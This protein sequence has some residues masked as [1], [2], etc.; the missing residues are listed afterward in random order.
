[1]SL[2][3]NFL[4]IIL[5]SQFVFT[6]AHANRTITIC[7]DINYWY[8]FSFVNDSKQADGL[9]I[10]ITREALRRLNLNTKYILRPWK[11]CL[12]SAELGEVDAIQSASYKTKRAEYLHYP[13]DA[14]QT[15]VS[16]WRLSQVEYFVI[17]STLKRDGSA[18]TYEFAGN[19]KSLPRPVRAEFGYSIVGDLEKE[20]IKVATAHKTL[21]LYRQLVNSKAGCVISLADIANILQEKEEFKGNLKVHDLPVKSKSYFLPFAKSSK[22][23]TNQDH[24]DIWNMISSIRDDGSLIQDWLEKY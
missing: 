9:H 4:L 21:A 13:D 18:Q 7:A 16:K 14:G 11:R 12:L 23:L 24:N 2:F 10:D 5:L 20:G 6:N 19:I 8:P 17:T 1:M 15:T 3:R 22:T